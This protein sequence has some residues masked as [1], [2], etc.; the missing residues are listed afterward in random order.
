M[1]NNPV[2]ENNLKYISVYSQELVNKI[3]S[4]KELFNS[5]ELVQN[6]NN[7]YNF[8]F[9]NIYVH[10]A[11]DPEL[12]AKKIR[13]SV[14]KNDLNTIHVV[15][16]LGLGYLLTEFADNA[17]GK[18]I[19]YEPDLEILRATLEI[20]DFSKELASGKVYIVNNYEDYKK[21]FNALSAFGVTTNFVF[22]SFYKYAYPNEFKQILKETQIMQNISEANIGFQKKL[23]TKYIE[24]LYLDFKKRIETPPLS[25]LNNVFA[26][27]P[28]LIVSAGPSLKKNIDYIKKNRDKVIIFAVGTALKVLI[29]NGITPDFL[30]VIEINDCSSQVKDIDTKDI[31]FIS[32]AYVNYNFLKK[33]YKRSF[34]TYSREN[35]ANIWFSSLLDLEFTDYETKGTVS[36]NALYSAKMLGCNPI[37]LIGQD[38]AYS[39]GD[40]YS[41][42]S[43]YGDLY[44]SKKD[45]G[46]YEIRVRNTENYLKALFSDNKKLEE[47]KERSIA[48]LNSKIASMTRE[49]VLVKGQLG[50]TLPTSPAYALF[51]S[52]FRDFALRNNTS[53]TLIN[54]SEGGAFIEG[55]EYRK[56]SDVLG[57]LT[58]KIDV[59]AILNSVNIE[60][61]I[62]I[63][64][65]RQKLDAEIN[66]LKNIVN[67][68]QKE[69]RN[70]TNFLREIHRA[71]QLTPKAQ[72]YLKSCL[73]TF[74]E[75]INN[76]KKTSQ[77][78]A[79]S[80]FVEE[81]FL[82][83]I[84]KDKDEK[85]DYNTQ[86]EIGEAI[87]NY[88]YL[89]C[90][91]II[92]TIK[93]VEELGNNLDESI[94]TK[95]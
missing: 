63:F 76:Q 17:K 72:K 12:E 89:A 29:S 60:H 90:D 58:E 73:E 57:N 55:F 56:L 59:E 35:K 93:S 13:E 92:K 21:I 32:E 43:V 81:S 66:I 94:I 88:Y 11:K 31:N 54:A 62:E 39:D 14:A 65:I 19:V 75:I 4:V 70:A 7:Q 52:Y 80:A 95:G 74:V 25:V 3:K 91:K 27:K 64:K 87:K 84:L 10:Y 47:N 44:C 36:Y 45:D 48:Y 53:I 26:N 22:L 68:L 8:V 16:G 78:Y 50:E 1:I 77:L 86:K 41:K 51:I 49:L 38:L 82:G 46:S 18:V 20:V 5:F 24:A 37:I 79:I 34:M 33:D 15:F 9:N 83:W 23:G 67:K 42:D 28:A 85:Y 40:C 69:Q 30:N 71:K 6:E 61:N 2:L